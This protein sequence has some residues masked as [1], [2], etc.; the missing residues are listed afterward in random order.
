[1]HSVRRIEIFH[2]KNF[3]Q[4]FQKLFLMKFQK[5]FL[6]KFQTLFLIK[7]EKLFAINNKIN[8]AIN[9]STNGRYLGATKNGTFKLL[10][11]GRETATQWEY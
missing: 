8:L 1:M 4:K 5:L 9:R 10:D 7:F 11:E 3:I 2:P 6:M